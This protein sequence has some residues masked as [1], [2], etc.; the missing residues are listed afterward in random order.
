MDVNNT[1]STFYKYVVSGDSISCGGVA[2]I[3][4][5]I[6]SYAI[7]KNVK[8]WTWMKVKALDYGCFEN[9]PTGNL[10]VVDSTTWDTNCSLEGR[11]FEG[12]TTEGSP[13]SIWSVPGRSDPA[14]Y[15]TDDFDFLTTF[16]FQIANKKSPGSSCQTTVTS[17][18]SASASATSETSNYTI[19][20]GSISFKTMF[21]LGA[22]Q[23]TRTATSA[24]RSQPFIFGYQP[25]VDSSALIA[26]GYTDENISSLLTPQLGD[27]LLLKISNSVKTFYCKAPDSI[28]GSI[29]VPA[30]VMNNFSGSTNFDL[31]RYKYDTQNLGANVDFLVLQRIG[32]YTNGNDSMGQAGGTVNVFVGD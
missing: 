3:I 11:F 25:A 8:D 7:Y 2:Q 13:R 28:E 30:S 15:F 19:E 18:V 32:Q 12:A 5:T 26:A 31:T 14:L 6:S 29:T 21:S 16:T 20:E 27:F 22:T 9:L 23:T 24:S 10:T 17:R 1:S 4:P